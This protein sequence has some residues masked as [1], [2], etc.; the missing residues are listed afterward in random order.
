MTREEATKLL[1]IVK[2]DDLLSFCAQNDKDDITN[3]SFGRF[4]LLSVCY[5]YNAKKIIKRFGKKLLN[6]DEFEEVF[7]PISIY[8]DFKKSAKKSLRL[9][10]GKTDK[11]KPIEMLSILGK[12]KKV[13]KVFSQHDSKEKI[14]KIYSYK[15]Q[16]IFS[17]KKNI[18]ISAKK[19]KKGVKIT[20]FS[21]FASIFSAAALFGLYIGIF[22]LGTMWSPKLIYTAAQ[23]SKIENAEAVKLQK[24]ITLKNELYFQNFKGKLD[25]NGKTIKIKFSIDKPLFET[26]EGEVKNINFVID[27]ENMNVNE[28]IGFLAQAN[29][30]KIE[31]LNFIIRSNIDIDSENDT[32][33]SVFV[34]TNNGIIKNCNADLD[35]NITK[36][37]EKEASFSV[38]SN[39]NNGTIENCQTSNGSEVVSQN[40]D[41]CGICTENNN[42]IIS[43]KNYSSI[44]QMSTLEKWS[45]NVAGISLINNGTISK[46]LNYGELTAKSEVSA[47][48]ATVFVGGICAT[49]YALI[50]E[51]KNV[52]DINAKS[53]D[54]T[55]VAGGICA[56]CTISSFDGNPTIDRCGTEGEFSISKNL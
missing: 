52:A 29:E 28:D 35:I 3:I 18:K 45:P 34:G 8:Q 46:C 30:G 12:D 6:I 22:G 13:K 43:S 47:S 44:T 40:V 48:E 50:S 9:Y 53:E 2:Q 36:S 1:N 41:V 38:F 10:A 56:F 25:G 17:N 7:E 20:L 23:L 49:N 42:Q 33:V 15:N 14:E 16:K 37:S 31:N 39:I 19:M 5:L 27:V 26:L 21:I 24:N 54:S 32:S 11:I 51:S 55:I 4:P